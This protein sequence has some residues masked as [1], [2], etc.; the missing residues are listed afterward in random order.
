MAGH[1]GFGFGQEHFLCWSISDG[2][3]NC[4]NFSASAGDMCFSFSNIE[5]HN[6]GFDLAGQTGFGFAGQTGFGI[7]GHVGFDLAGQTGFCLAGQEEC[8]L[9]GLLGHDMLLLLDL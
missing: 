3:V 7:E 9:P 1:T 2:Q 8:A 4:R 5:G 6:F